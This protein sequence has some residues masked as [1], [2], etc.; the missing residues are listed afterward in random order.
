VGTE[1][2]E[3]CREIER[4][5]CQKNDGHL[6]R[7]VGPSFDRVCSWASRGVPFKVACRGIDRYVERY[8]A[9]GPRRRPVRI[10]FCEADVLDVFDEWRRAVGL[11]ANVAAGPSGD[12]TEPGDA[13]GPE[14]SSTR[15]GPSL[16][17]HLERVLLRLT[18]ARTSGK[19]D[20]RFD[21]VLDQVGRELDLARGDAR[22]IRGDARRDLLDR[23][24]ALDR[25]MLAAARAALSDAELGRLVEDAEDELS[26]FRAVM[27]AEAFA[28]ARTNATD[29][30]LRERFALPTLT[31]F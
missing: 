20:A 21:L 31:F 3:Y 24:A 17:S 13:A 6:I 27:V 22:G 30:L 12:A 5:L 2:V 19:V 16:P 26:P 14:E 8:Y 29:R 28:R 9:K 10:D 7:I 18:A 11:P 4:Y 1:P 15:R 23:L 25:E